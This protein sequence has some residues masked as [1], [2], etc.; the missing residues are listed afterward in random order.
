MTKYVYLRWYNK[1]IYFLFRINDMK[2]KDFS[3][4]EGVENSLQIGAL[5]KYLKAE[6]KYMDK[7]RREL[8]RKMKEMTEKRKG[9]SRQKEKKFMGFIYGVEREVKKSGF[10]M[11][12]QYATTL[13]GEGMMKKVKEFLEEG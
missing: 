3:W 1:S 7:I 8:D 13:F 12:F 9:M 2:M 11:G 10:I 5:Y 4:A 6:F